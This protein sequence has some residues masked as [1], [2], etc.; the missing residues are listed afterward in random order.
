MATTITSS[1]VVS[2]F[3]AYYID[4]GQNEGNIHQRLR[5]VFETRNAF[6]VIET[7]DTQLRETNVTY[8]EVLQSFQTTF[9]PKGGITF[10]PRTIQLFNVKVDQLFLPDALKNQWLAFL[11]SN[12]LDR[13]TWPFVRFFIERYV[14]GQISHD[15]ETKGI[16]TGVQANP[17]PGTANNA[18][19]TMNGVKTIINAGITATTISTIATGTPSTTPATWCTQVEDFTK[20][21]PELYW[22]ETMSLNMS[23]TLARRYKEGRRTKYNSNY[24]QV[25][26]KMAVED[27]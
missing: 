4:E 14:M 5:E 11:T 7:E 17:T 8:S 26:D 16:Y 25:T 9:T 12:N 27:V 19:D 6:T 18:I 2:D 13:T 23:R 24:E 22:G 1:Q 10:T 21:I 3:G 15:L 20:G